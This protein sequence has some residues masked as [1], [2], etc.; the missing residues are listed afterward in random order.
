MPRTKAERLHNMRKKIAKRMKIIR[1]WATGSWGDNEPHPWEME[2]HRAHKFNLNC[3]CKM[4]HYYKHIGNSKGK[5]THKEEAQREVFL[6][7]KESLLEKEGGQ[8]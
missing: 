4:C 6:H 3:G 5:F 7:E 1:G 8:G 2:P